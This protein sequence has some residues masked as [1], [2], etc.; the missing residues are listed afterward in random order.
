[1]L[2]TIF[3]IREDIFTDVGVNVLNAAFANTFQYMPPELMGTI[4]EM[5]GAINQ[6]YMT[7]AGKLSQKN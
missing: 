7:E 4:N 6:A 5:H 1:M 3:F 2:R